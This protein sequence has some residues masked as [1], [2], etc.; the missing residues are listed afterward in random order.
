MSDIINV[1]F[2]LLIVIIIFIFRH[3]KKLY[4][5]Q[6]S[7]VEN[8][9]N[10]SIL[11]NN[12]MRFDKEIQPKKFYNYEVDT[13][14]QTPK[15]FSNFRYSLEFKFGL[16]I[17][18]NF[19]L[20]NQETLGLADNLKLMV[21]NNRDLFMCSEAEYYEI[22]DKN[23]E[24]NNKYG[25]V[26]GLYYQHFLFFISP[27]SRIDNINDLKIYMSEE[28]LFMN[29]MEKEKNKILKVGIPQKN[30]NSYLDALKIFNSVG[31]DINR[32]DYSNLQF[33]FDSE[34]NLI[35]RLKSTA[36]PDKKIDCFYL[37]T[38]EKHPYLQELL[39]VYN[40]NVVSTE[41][42]NP[43]LIRSNYG[44]NH[45][46]KNRI[47]KNIFSKIIRKKNIYQNVSQYDL[48]TRLINNATENLIIGGSYLNVN[49]TRII[50]VASNLVN[51]NYVKLF[52]EHL[53]GNIDN[54]RQKLQKYLFN[55]NL[56]N[57]LPRCLDPYEISY[58]NQKFAYH[59]GAYEFFTDMHFI[60]DSDRSMDNLYLK[61]E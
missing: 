51:T 37:T 58:V 31:I 2:L 20:Q 55:P 1:K 33:V 43:N 48:S 53:Y 42:I 36:L 50:I 54:L 45:L 21:E 18:K 8:Y 19:D 52:L 60:S 38:S 49:S 11:G 9:E 39:Q 28:R 13:L 14:Y 25:Y 6:L 10:H 46:F 30:T 44:G 23:P 5:H 12:F 17:S 61:N 32:K 24:L 27:E 3:R 57:Y 59:P 29:E 22:L 47:H 15:I 40:I 34:K 56:K 35:S 41:S 26:C 16:E 7:Q 4:T